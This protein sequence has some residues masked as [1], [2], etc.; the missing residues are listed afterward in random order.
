MLGYHT[1]FCYIILAAVATFVACDHF[2]SDWYI[3]IN[4]FTVGAYLIDKLAAMANIQR[5][6]EIVLYL[7]GLFGGWIG[8]IY[9]QQIFRHKT[10]KHSF[11][12]VFLCTIIIFIYFNW[13]KIVTIFSNNENQ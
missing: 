5:I 10:R 4:I 13:I 8:A 6:P 3:K 1:D 7:L 2:N 11:Q 12:F 9:A